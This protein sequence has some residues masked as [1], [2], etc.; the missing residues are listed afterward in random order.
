M[1]KRLFQNP[2][3][4]LSFIFGLSLTV[5]FSFLTYGL[6]VVFGDMAAIYA[7]YDYVFAAAVY[8][9][10]IA[11]PVVMGYFWKSKSDRYWDGVFLGL[12]IFAVFVI[13]YEFAKDIGSNPV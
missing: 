10:D 1:K 12:L 5:S 2:S 13:A 11:V 8:G 7:P 6:F 4:L 9:L 3:N